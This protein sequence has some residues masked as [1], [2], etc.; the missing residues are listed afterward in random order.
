MRDETAFIT[1]GPLADLCRAVNNAVRDPDGK[2][3]SCILAAA[4]AM[5]ILRERGQQADV[6]RVEAAVFP[7]GSCES[8]TVL[9]RRRRNGSKADPD[10]WSG[11][12]VTIVED[13]WLLDPTITQVERGRCPPLVIELPTWW[14]KGGKPIWVDI[15]G[16]VNGMV[17][18]TALPGRG[19]FK[20]APDFRC[21]IRQIYASETLRQLAAISARR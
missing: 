12:L 11:H 14:L 5:D 8:A 19:G 3:N 17:R 13:R 20:N 15:I 4:T 9:G 21:G 18:Y 2:T 6:M 1:E 7:G 16:T 10:L